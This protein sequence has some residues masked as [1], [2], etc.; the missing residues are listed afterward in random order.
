MI[1]IL[2]VS[3]YTLSESCYNKKEYIHNPAGVIKFHLQSSSYHNQG[4]LWMGAVPG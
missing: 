2:H 1:S 4:L 3:F